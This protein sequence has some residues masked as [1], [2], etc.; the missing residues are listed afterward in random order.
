[1]QDP[2]K[3]R[4]G[5]FHKLINGT[6]TYY[7]KGKTYSEESFRVFMEVE[8]K[9]HIFESETMTRLHTGELLKLEV[10][11]VL[12]KKHL[13]ETVTLKKTIGKTLVR[14]VFNCN[15]TNHFLS[16]EI[17]T[18]QGLRRQKKEMS[19]LYHISTPTACLSL[20]CT[21]SRN[22]NLYGRTRYVYAVSNNTWEFKQPMTEED[23]YIE[24]ASND[25]IPFSLKGKSMSGKKYQMYKHDSSD[26]I[27]EEPVIFYASK[28]LG[29]PYLVQIGEDI[30]IEINNLNYKEPS[31]FDDNGMPV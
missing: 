4:K 13:P 31:K 16:Y 18:P 28:Y 29:I 2:E 23:F 10:E 3:K 19:G 21:F 11:Y 6:Y 24:L 7:N 8:E 5:N 9:F 22:M 14:E 15:W 20:I 30:R 27:N 12:N 25:P 17:H 26:N 1:M